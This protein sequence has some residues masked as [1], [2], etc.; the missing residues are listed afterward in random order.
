MAHNL[1][2]LILWL[3]LVILL[4][5]CRQEPPPTTGIVEANKYYQQFFGNPP[6]V[7]EGRAYARVAFL[8]LKE[9]SNRVSAVP[10]YLFKE[11]GQLE[12]ILNR[13]SGGELLL[14][15]DSP[16]FNPFSS[17][18]SLTVKSRH[19]GTV[20]LLL[21][22]PNDSSIDHEI[23]LPAIVET[24]AQFD[25]IKRVIVLVDNEPVSGMP[26][27]G[28][29]SQPQR[30]SDAAPPGLIMITGVWDEGAKDPEEIT[31]NFD[32]PVTVN[33][34]LMSHADGQKVTG[35]FFSS[36]F[37][38]AIII[39]PENPA[40]FREGIELIVDWEVT[41]AKGRAG[42]GRSTFSLKRFE[43]EIELKDFQK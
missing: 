31:V 11:S 37:Q 19:D 20:T 4:A 15:T 28:Y 5:A 2:K 34:F 23:F 13:L 14:P 26:D 12:S 18:I 6:E 16:L 3:T 17:R 32:R 43:H 27:D 36:V 39:H 42:T 9:D 41:D 40:R 33:K 8:P 24:A 7:R 10:I 35:E 38:M 29:Q 21:E 1:Y 30:I 25:D 22:L